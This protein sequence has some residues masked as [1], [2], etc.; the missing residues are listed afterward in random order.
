MKNDNLLFLYEGILTQKLI[1]V[2][3][4]IIEN[5]AKINLIGLGEIS[6]I[7]SVFIE[8]SQ[9]IINYSKAESNE[10]KY[11]PY[12]LIEIR[13]DNSSNYHIKSENIINEEDKKKLNTNLS[14]LLGLRDLGLKETY[15][16]LRKS[17]INSHE[18]GSGIGLCEIIMR[19][20]NFNF[21][22]DKRMTN[23]YNF[24]INLQIKG[25]NN[26]KSNN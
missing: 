13:K 12:G 20:N 26:E 24:C 1:V 25:K 23:K 14:S 8:L 17:G 19:C 4:Q 21:S 10:C 16:S 11:G 2:L 6:R 15:K 3:V 18:K 5:N 22:F 9:N 7:A